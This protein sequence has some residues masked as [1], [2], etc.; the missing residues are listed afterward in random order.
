[1]IEER[2]ALLAV[3]NSMALALASSLELD[4]AFA[5]FIAELSTSLPF[6]RAAIILEEGGGM[7]RVVAA[8]G[9][10]ADGSFAPGRRMELAG[11]SL[12]AA[13]AGRTTYTADLVEGGGGGRAGQLAAELGLRSRVVVPLLAGPIAVGTLSLWRKLAHGFRED[14]VELATLLGRLAG[15][16]VQNIRAYD[17]ERARVEELARLSELRDD[18]VSLVSH[19]LR[20]PVASLQAAAETLRRRV[21]ELAPEQ[22]DAL[23]DVV[24]DESRRL[25]GLVADVLDTSRIDSGTFTYT[26][27]EVDVGEIVRETVAAA[28]LAHAAARISFEISPPVP[29]VRADRE[30]IRQV[31][32]NLVEN[33]VKYSGDGAVGATVSAADGHVHV[34]VADDGPG[35]DPEHH[36]LIFE[37]FGRVFGEGPTLPGSGLGLF[38]SRSI[39]EAHGGTL[40]VR[41]EPGAGSTFS[42]VLP[43]SS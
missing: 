30:R 26:F 27:A 16:A 43:A 24:A 3:A 17:A 1:V 29:P 32:T 9:V 21:E 7:G 39:A 36:E 4:E 18:L 28:E 23:L 10:G 19:E 38:I 5:A 6:D 33:A 25:A 40:E 37:K 22:R 31:L 42:L 20:S 8:A 35:I 34:D 14:E 15:T 41:S 11:T 12:E 2:S 13:L